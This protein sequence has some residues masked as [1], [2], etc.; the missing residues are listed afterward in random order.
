MDTKKTWIAKDIIGLMDHIAPP[1]LAMSGDVIGLQVGRAS[2]KVRKVALALDASLAS[3]ALA[4]ETGADMLITHHAMLYRPAQKIDTDSWRGQAIQTALTHDLTVFSAHTNFDIAEGGVND[5]LAELVGLEDIE[6]LDVTGYE[7]LLKLCVY[8]PVEHADSVRDAL[9][10]AGAG[11]IGLY[12]HCTFNTNGVGTFLPREGA[13]PSIGKVGAIESVHEVKI[14]TI[15][16]ESK[17][18]S[19]VAAMK[20]AHPYEKVAYDLYS[21]RNEGKSYGIGRVGNLAEPMTLRD[22]AKFVRDR[23]GITHI[24]YG[25]SD[26]LQ[27][28]RVA[29]LGGAGSRW[30]SHAL[31]KGAQVLLT[32]DCDHHTVSDAWVDGLAVMDATH[33]A[34]ERPALY[35]L[36]NRLEKLT[37]QEVEFVVLNHNEDPFTWI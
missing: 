1:S 20:V 19:I 28:S 10:Q 5:V 25:G 15:V 14:E 33:S 9:G 4:C 22:F 23:L 8:V 36:Q 7:S 6:I 26:E 18:A 31:R 3:V 34:I 35:A 11:H 2:R 37:N 32:S 16:P 29:V 21:L 17:V 13:N 12:S 24:R 27:V 30:V